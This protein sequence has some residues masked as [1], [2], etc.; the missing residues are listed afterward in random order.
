VG[1]KHNLEDLIRSISV[2]K[3][4]RHSKCFSMLRA[5][6]AGGISSAF[7]LAGFTNLDVVRNPSF[8]ETPCVESTMRDAI[9]RQ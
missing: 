7:G 4:R 6:V 1:G 2:M 3:S 9:R 5:R 8:G